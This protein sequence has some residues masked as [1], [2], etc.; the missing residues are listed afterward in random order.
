MVIRG[1]I[2]VSGTSQLR[3]SAMQC[4]VR[5]SACSSGSRCWLAVPAAE[6]QHSAAQAT[7]SA[8]EPW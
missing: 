8:P 4:G 3:F 2:A 5:A 7:M 1:L 6:E